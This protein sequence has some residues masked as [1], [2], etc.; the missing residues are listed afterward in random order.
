MTA[1]RA[2]TY[3]PSLL[4]DLT[5]W[6]IQNQLGL[7]D[8]DGLGAL[9]SLVRFSAAS[10]AATSNPSI[11]GGGTPRSS[12]DSDRPLAVT[13]SGNDGRSGD[14]VISDTPKL[15]LWVLMNLASNDLLSPRISAAPGCIEDLV[16]LMMSGVRGVSKLR[17]WAAVLLTPLESQQHHEGWGQT[18]KPLARGIDFQSCLKLF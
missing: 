8:T 16:T 9:L 17:G 12:A 3:P 7:V 4:A 11:R 15:A 2:R 5:S 14:G 6:K 10:A 18:F 1:G 13:A